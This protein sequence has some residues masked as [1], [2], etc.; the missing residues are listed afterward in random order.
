MAQEV[1]H[2]FNIKTESFIIDIGSNDGTLLQNF[3]GANMKTLG[4][5]PAS[6]ICAISK[7][8]GIDAI[9][10]YFCSAVAKEVSRE[11][12]QADVITATN[13]LLNDDGILVIEVPYLVDMLEK[14]EFDTVY[15]EHLSYFAI[16]PLVTFFNNY[17]MSI[18]HVKRIGIHGGSIRIFVQKKTE[19]TPPS[20]A[21]LL[22]LEDDLKLGYLETYLKFSEAVTKIKIELL[23]ILENLKKQ[24]VSIS[25]YGAPA[26]GNTLLNYCGID[27]YI[28]DYIIDT[29]PYKQGRYTPGM[30]IPI[31]PAEHFYSNPTDYSLLLAWNYSIAILEKEKVYRENG[32]K[33]I[34]PVPEPHIV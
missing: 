32:G 14:T 21:A 10:D 8:C 25:G 13:V 24:G 7:S 27:T 34:I 12:G 4:I 9:N 3:K 29:T 18:V 28:L 22:K 26:K 1:I 30:K 2:D 33:F 20:V 5:E 16:R 15:H 11:I 17:N 19:S 6:N 23:A 31:F